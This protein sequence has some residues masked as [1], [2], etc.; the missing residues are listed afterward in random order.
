MGIVSRWL[1]FWVIRLKNLLR[2]IKILAQ[3]VDGEP[4]LQLLKGS[5]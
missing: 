3:V 4:M 1:A 5:Q 2:A